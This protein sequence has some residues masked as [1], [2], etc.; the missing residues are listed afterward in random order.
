MIHRKKKAS[1]NEKGCRDS[2]ENVQAENDTEGKEWCG[3]EAEAPVG[4]CAQ[5]HEVAR[6]R[7]HHRRFPTGPSR[8]YRLPSAAV[9][10]TTRDIGRDDRYMIPYSVAMDM[11]TLSVS[12]FYLRLH[13]FSLLLM[14]LNSQRRAP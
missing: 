4:G 7:L 12:I 14:S 1:V 3:W 8:F 9:V 5:E 2:D 10:T 11:P 6:F 13:S